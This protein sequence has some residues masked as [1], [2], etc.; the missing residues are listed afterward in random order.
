MQSVESPESKLHILPL[1]KQADVR[2]GEVR[3]ATTEKMKVYFMILTLFRG[4]VNSQLVE[5]PYALSTI[6]AFYSL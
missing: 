4:R 3:S 1:S 5:M 2:S 6:K